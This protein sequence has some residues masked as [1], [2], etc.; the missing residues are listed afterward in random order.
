MDERYDIIR[1]VRGQ[2]YKYIRNYEPFKPYYQY[3]NTPEQGRLMREIR[4]VAKTGTLPPVAKKI[5]ASTKPVEELYDTQVD[6][7][8]TNNLAE[9][10]SYQHV[11]ERMRLVHINWVLD[12]RDLGLVPEPEIVRGEQQCG[13]RYAILWQPGGEALI[14]RLR[15]AATTSL[16]DESSMEEMLQATQDMEAAVRY[17]ATVSIGNLR[18]SGST[19]SDTM[20]Q[21]LSDKSA[22]VRVAAA[23]TLCQMEKPAAA[24]STLVDVLHNGA[25]WERLHAV[26]VLDV[27]D[28]MARPVLADIQKALDPRPDLF[29]RGKYTARVAS[30]AL[31]ELLGTNHAAR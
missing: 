18:S 14:E 27:I 21:L 23:R 15:N 13:S 29:Q 26:I 28:E 12:T 31:N 2:R 17:W 19:A 22:V 4:R 11:L 25:Q 20:E 30:R 6:S 3:M 5:L 7:H 8:E 10:L 16:A 1:A 24:L 9:D